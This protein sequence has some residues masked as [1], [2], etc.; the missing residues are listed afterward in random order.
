MQQ[1][2]KGIRVVEFAQFTS[3]SC[4]KNLSS[5]FQIHLDLKAVID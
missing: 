3:L 5:G 1:V 2:M 4:A